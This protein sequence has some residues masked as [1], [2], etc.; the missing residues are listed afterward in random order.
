[1]SRPIIT[2][3]SQKS[4][5]Q[6]S[7]GPKHSIIWTKGWKDYE[8]VEISK[9]KFQFIIDKNLYQIYIAVGILVDGSLSQLSK[10]RQFAKFLDIML[11][12]PAWKSL[13]ERHITQ[14]HVS[15]F[16]MK[17]AA[18][19]FN[20][21]KKMMVTMFAKAKLGNWVKKP[22]EQDTFVLSVDPANFKIKQ[23]EVHLPSDVLDC[24]DCQAR[25]LTYS[26]SCNDNCNE[27]KGRETPQQV[28]ES[29]ADKNTLAPK[30]AKID[31]H[32]SG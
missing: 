31:A 15:Y 28:D 13:V 22:S 18:R 2:N 9:G 19:E 5:R 17:K 11:L 25:D 3:T 6:P 30:K 20:D 27:Q 16:D 21:A 7:N 26:S 24:L 10:K 29:L 14:G 12:K 32:F 8:V 1:M 23:H 4:K